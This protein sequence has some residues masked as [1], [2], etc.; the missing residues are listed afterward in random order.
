MCCGLIPTYLTEISPS[1]LRGATGVFHQLFI[2][3]GILVSQVLGFRQLLGTQ[4]LWQFLL[5]M[6]IVPGILGSVLLLLFLNE[7]PKILL[8]QNKEP[9]ARKGLNLILI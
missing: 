3:I 9:K 4:K 1:A 2:T 6:P 5:A 7:P 8:S